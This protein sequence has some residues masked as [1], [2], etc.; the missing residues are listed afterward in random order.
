MPTEET[1][2]KPKKK[3]N[4]SGNRRGID[5]VGNFKNDP[6]K[7]SEASKKANKKD[8]SASICL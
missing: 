5:T 4:K 6:E 1:E 8:N 3:L 7:A 2:E